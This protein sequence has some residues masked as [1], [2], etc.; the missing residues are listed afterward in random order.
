MPKNA[1]F[2]LKNCKN[3]RTLGALSPNP[4]ISPSMTNS[5]ATRLDFNIMICFVSKS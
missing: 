5:L 1:V 4:G 2:L 3:R